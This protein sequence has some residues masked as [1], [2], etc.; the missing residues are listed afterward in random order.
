MLRNWIDVQFL[1]FN[2]KKNYNNKDYKNNK[3]STVYILA[4]DGGGQRGYIQ[5]V[6]LN[7]FLQQWGIN[8]N[9]LWK[10]FDV[11][12][13]T[14]VGGIQ[15][16]AYAKGMSPD[17]VI[18]FFTNA[19]KWIFTIRTAADVLAGSINASLPSNRPNLAQKLA[20]MGTSDPF[21]N[22]VSPDSN[23]GSSRLYSEMTSTFSDM[24]LQGLK[25]KVLIPA[26]NKTEE[27]FTLFSNAGLAGYEGQNELVKNVAAATSAA[28]I[29]L[30]SYSFQSGGISKTYLDGGIFQNNPASFGLT[31]GQQLKPTANRACVLSIGTGLGS[32]GFSPLDAAKLSSNNIRS[33]MQPN[34][35]SFA[36]LFA[37]I[38][39][40]MTGCQESVAQELLLRSSQYTLNKLYY[41]RFQYELDNENYDTDMDNTDSSSF[42]YFSDLTNPDYMKYLSDSTTAHYNADIENI[43]TFIGHLEA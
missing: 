5:A 28:P 27:K 24:T 16:L 21:Y 10:K 1:K 40:S 11:I 31:L 26:Y 39:Q 18:P 13:G 6:F 20:L 41:Y 7:L 30:P 19:G 35:N 37:L 14:S 22:S 17:E 23:Y 42:D 2:N 38:D 33:N 15:A 4:L 32:I 9:D 36:S 34:D 12:C 25:T 43:S 3:V 8:P 29:Y